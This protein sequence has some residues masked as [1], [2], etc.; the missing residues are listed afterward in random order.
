MAEKVVF[1]VRGTTR[2]SGEHI[3]E[4]VR[5][6]DA[7]GNFVRVNANEVAT[8]LIRAVDERTLAHDWI[9]QDES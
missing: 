6:A 7:L 4:I 3:Y 1:L 2:E 9:T 8:Y 5:D